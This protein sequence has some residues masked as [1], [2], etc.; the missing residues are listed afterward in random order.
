M[1]HLEVI[2]YGLNHVTT[3]VEGRAIELHQA[4]STSHSHLMSPALSEE[5][6]LLL[7]SPICEVF[8]VPHIS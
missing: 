3:L 8:R 2:K 6:V 1:T 7:R 4:F 5:L